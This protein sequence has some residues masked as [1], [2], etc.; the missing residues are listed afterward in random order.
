[1]KKNFNIC[2]KS[3]IIVIAVVVLIPQLAFANHKNSSSLQKKINKLDNDSV[4]EMAIP[5]MYGVNI[6][7][8][9]DS[10]GETK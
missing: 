3:I 5:I 8:I 1:M 6:N 7:Q 9:F 4:E 2:K 10:F